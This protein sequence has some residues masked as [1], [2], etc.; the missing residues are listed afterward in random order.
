MANE[1]GYR[2]DLA[3][4]ATKRI[5][6]GG[7]P[8]T[9]AVARWRGRTTTTFYLRDSRLDN[10]QIANRYLTENEVV[11]A[12]L[13]GD[14]PITP[15]EDAA[16]FE[17]ECLRPISPAEKE[18][19]RIIIR[20]VRQHGLGGYFDREMLVDH[21]AD[22][23]RLVEQWQPRVNDGNPYHAR[24][25]V[26]SMSREVRIYSIAE[27]ATRNVR[28]LS[29]FEKMVLAEIE[30]GERNGL[31]PLQKRWHGQHEY[32][33]EKLLK[34]SNGIYED[35]IRRRDALAAACLYLEAGG[36]SR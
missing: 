14:R 16:R 32:A 15:E 2:T 27:R 6:K 23:K 5:H 13:A 7:V 36:A 33:T 28:T 25:M 30:Y 34:W 4:R 26:A 24:K 3:V 17:R 22:R 18:Q 31:E 9:L 8:E 21:L 10:D 29:D 19:L 12:A 20:D 1:Y 35:A 11:A